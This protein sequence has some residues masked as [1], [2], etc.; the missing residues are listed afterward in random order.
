MATALPI[1]KY[2]TKGGKQEKITQT[3]WVVGDL[4]QK[5]SRELLKNALTFMVRCFTYKYVFIYISMYSINICINTLHFL[6][7]ATHRVRPKK[8][9]IRCAV[10]SV[11]HKKAEMCGMLY[12]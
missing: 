10:A 4:N 7:I 1:F 5:E 11:R 9:N 6:L 3:I 12:F 8:D 2:F